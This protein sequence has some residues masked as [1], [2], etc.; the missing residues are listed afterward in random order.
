MSGAGGA[1]GGGG[2]SIDSAEA[3]WR[4]LERTF[5]RQADYG[6]HQVDWV[7]DLAVT[8][9]H[10]ADW[11]ALERK[12][13]LGALRAQLKG[14]CAE[15]AVCEQVAN[16]AKHL[17]LSDDRLKPFDVA[18][19]VRTSSVRIGLIKKPPAP[20][21]PYVAPFRPAVL[22]TDKDGR[23]WSATRLFMVVLIFWRS[24]LGLLDHTSDGKEG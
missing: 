20:G 2:Q 10:M 16:G 18:S 23:H 19:G 7:F 14:R 1:D 11:V 17:V 15:L 24:E 4:K 9:W 12:I 21:K 3:L 8:A 6:E 13:N 5:Y 22:I